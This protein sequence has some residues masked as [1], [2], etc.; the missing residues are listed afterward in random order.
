MPLSEAQYAL[1]DT[2]KEILGQGAVV[3][4]PYFANSRKTKWFSKLPP[5][6]RVG[7]HGYLWAAV[8]AIIL[9]EAAANSW[10]QLTGEPASALPPQIFCCIEICRAKMIQTFGRLS[11]HAQVRLPR[12]CARRNPCAAS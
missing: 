7:L 5:A 9:A 6:L 11:S 2:W 10:S 3:G 1:S 12:R 8:P 4:N